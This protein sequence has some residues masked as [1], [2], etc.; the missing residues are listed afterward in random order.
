MRLLMV[1]MA[2]AA[3]GCGRV[4]HKV[5]GGAQ[6]RSDVNVTVTVSLCDDLIGK[7]KAECVNA[8]AKLAAIA[9]KEAEDGN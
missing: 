9:A 8:L 7:D 6:T 4:E 1:G 2:F 3:I 5:S